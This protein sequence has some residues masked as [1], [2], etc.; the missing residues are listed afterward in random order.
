MRRLRVSV[1]L[2]LAAL[3]LAA[4][5]LYAVFGGADFGGGIW[6]L[7]ATGPR[8]RR[9]REVVAGAIGPIWEA[10]HIWLIAVIVLLFTCF[11]K[12]YAAIG[13]GL[14]FP[15]TAMLFGIC[16]RGVAF[17]FRKY[18]SQRSSIYDGWSRLFAVTSLVTP[19]TLGVCLG[20]ASGG[21]L[22]VDPSTGLPTADGMFAWTSAFPQS[23]GLFVVAVFAFLAAVFLTL[24]TTEVE[25][26][27]DFRVRALASA[28]A[29]TVL[30]W[31]VFAFS[32]EG[33]PHLR[34]GLW[35]SWWAAPF[36]G[37]TAAL[38]GGILWSLWNRRYAV[39]RALAVVQVVAVVAG[40]GAAQYPFIVA[41]DLTFANTIA[42]SS[43]TTTVAVGMTVGLVA[44]A[45]AYVWLFR[46]F[47]QH[48]AELPHGGH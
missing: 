29:V 3:T 40:F 15:L 7:F 10:N 21:A 2:Y 16:L 27:E 35:S 13:T 44:L 1:E 28:V 31:M 18:D 26:Q 20:A 4:L 8:A 23:V 5:V 25:L 41:P 6:D 19:Y 36:Q 47:K 37:L 11:P 12:A 14:H 32:V 22:R 33:A 42:P 48:G 9:Q 43:V 30:A 24:E 45:P 46:L 39:A 34:A 38:G 17:V